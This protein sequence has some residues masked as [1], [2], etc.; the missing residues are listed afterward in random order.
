MDRLID[1]MMRFTGA[2]SESVA[3]R[4]VKTLRR[5]RAPLR[6]LATWDARLL[7]WFR[8]F[9]PQPLYVWITYWM[10]PGIRKWRAANDSLA[11]HAGS[12][13]KA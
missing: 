13:A 10:L 2:T 8:R 5:H 1:R 9:T 4:V 12:G 11:Q 7:W 6:V 3:R